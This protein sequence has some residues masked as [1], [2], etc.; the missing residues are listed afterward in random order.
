MKNRN[1]RTL[2]LILFLGVMVIGLSAEIQVQD[3]YIEFMGGKTWYRIWGAGAE[4]I[5]LILIHGGPGVNSWYFEPMKPLADERPVILYDQRGGGYSDPLEPE[6]WNVEF[7]VEELRQLIQQLGLKKYHILGHSWGTM[8]ATD[9]AITQPEGLVGLIHSS[10][11]IS[12]P[13]WAADQRKWLKTLP[14]DVQEIIYWHEE[15]GIFDTPEY[16][17]AMLMYYNLYIC[18]LDP[19][20]DIL[21]KALD[22]E[23]MNIYNTMWG[24][25]EFTING[26]LH[27]Y[28]RTPELHLIDVPTLF[29][30]GRFDEAMPDTVRY[31]QSL[32]PG[33]QIK[34]FNYS[35]HTSMLEQPHRFNEEIREFLNKVERRKGL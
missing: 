19:W 11:C 2:V 27:D 9:F 18:R 26:T 31:Y 15:H 23:N 30:C 16:Q 6:Y 17:E 25:S 28:D 24:A 7:F 21:V 29:T 14:E 22:A 20:P 34:V 5:P 32:I 10:P 4:G 8:V 35:S 3:G 13:M 12:I 1:L 33:A